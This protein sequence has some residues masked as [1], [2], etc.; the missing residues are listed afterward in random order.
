VLPLGTITV[1]EQGK[2]LSDAGEMATAGAVGFSDDGRPVWDARLMRYALTN[3]LR[4]RRPIVNHCEEPEIAD[5]GVMNEGRVSDLLGLKGQPAAAEEAMVA[6]DIELARETGGRLHLAHISTRGSVELLRRARRDALAVTAEVTPHHL[7]MTEEWVL[8]PH[9]AESN[10]RPDRT[11][12]AYD[13]RTKVAPPLRTEDDRQAVL[14]ALAD[15]LIDV[16]ATDHAPHRSIDKECTFD[17]AAFGITGFETALGSLLG[18]VEGGH[19]S[20]M[21]L[22]ARLTV[23]PCRIFALPYG[24]LDVGSAADV[25]IFDPIATWVVDASRFYSKGKNTPLDGHTL[26]GLVRYTLVDGEVV[27][28]RSAL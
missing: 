23:D 8:G 10:G 11:P 5:G 14:A 2:A 12:C 6:R 20:L 21:D 26:Q 18:L 28:E 22:I 24:S 7:T 3:S 4:H 27:F 9:G 25:V 16:V 15:G 1:G 13:T 17:E 19:I